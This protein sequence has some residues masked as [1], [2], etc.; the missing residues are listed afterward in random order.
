[1]D[2]TVRGR[3]A[4][5]AHDLVTARIRATATTGAVSARS[6]RGPSPTGAKPARASRSSSP[7]ESPPSGP[8]TT[9]TSVASPSGSR[10][11][12]PS[13][14]GS[15][16]MPSTTLGTALGT[17]PGPAP[18]LVPPHDGARGGPDHDLVGAD[19][20]ELLEARVHPIALD[21]RHER[22]HERRPR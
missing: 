22:A 18:R 10:A 11:S 16:T 8:L 19:L 2:A 6:T 5:G 3:T 14:A 7:G 15:S 17:A 13:P 4:V 20:D 9:V 12:S 1:M 21:G